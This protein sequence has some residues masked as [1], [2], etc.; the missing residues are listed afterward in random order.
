MAEI[1]N[2]STESGTRRATQSGAQRYL[3]RPLTS[4]AK[5]VARIND[6]SSHGGRIIEG[7]NNVFTNGR[8]TAR[9]NDRHTCPIKGHG[10]TPMVTSSNTVFVNGR[11]VVRVGD[12]AGCGAVITQGSPNVFAG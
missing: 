4:T 6:P 1:N 5:A 11:G 7:S 3:E 8:Q 12:R 10:T 9:R 2:R